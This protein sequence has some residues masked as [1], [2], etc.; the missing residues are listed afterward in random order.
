MRLLS[1]M[2]RSLLWRVR[3]PEPDVHHRRT[4]R[5][6]QSQRLCGR[7][8]CLRPRLV[9]VGRLEADRE[10]VPRRRID[11]VAERDDRHPLRRAV[12]E[13][14]VAV[15]A[16]ALAPEDLQALREVGEAER[17]D[18]LV[19]PVE[20]RELWCAARPPSDRLLVGEVNADAPLDASVRG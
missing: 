8:E 3:N 2:R 19:L 10:D 16:L 13:S 18:D 7:E 20:G 12:V 14:V 5:L 9:P 6:A 11:D 1:Q 17:R 4:D 15:N